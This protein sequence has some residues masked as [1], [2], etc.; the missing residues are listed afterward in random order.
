M[1]LEVDLEELPDDGENHWELGGLT[2]EVTT[3]G[4][5]GL[6]DL[7]ENEGEDQ[8]A[9]GDGTISGEQWLASRP[10][11]LTVRIAAP[12]GTATDETAAAFAASLHE[13]RVVMSLLPD[14]TATRLLR[15]RRVGEPAKR[16][17]VRPAKGRALTVP[18]DVR[19]LA[20][21]HADAVLRLE[22]PDPVVLSDEYH[23]YVFEAGETATITNA[24]SFTAVQPSAWWLSADVPVT[25]ENLD[26]DEYVRFPSGPV[27]VGR[28]YDI[29]AP[30]SGNL[31]Y[32]PGSTLYPR[33]PL[34]RPGD[35]T[36]K[37]SAA[38]TFRWRDTW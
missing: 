36:I 16:I 21:D 8:D 7:A 26:H 5:E 33:W 25:I 30:V 27:T 37:A 35:N 2:L 14:R 23:E 10:V 15:W 34:L 24:G 13:L 29:S 6:D 17:A 38:C 18:G 12:D 9:A 4:D 19:R 1:P 32:G 28:N 11:G 3:D 20:Y 31:C 22:A